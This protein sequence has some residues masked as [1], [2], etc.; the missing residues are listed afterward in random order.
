MGSR[1]RKLRAIGALAAL[2]AGMVGVLVKADEPPRPPVIVLEI[3]GA[4]GP[5]TADYLH[6][7]FEKAVAAHAALIVLRMDTPGGL[8]TS[9]REIIRDILASEVP[10]ATLVA[11]AGARAASA[12]TYI[13]YASHIAAMVP[14]TNLGAA[15]PVSLGGGSPEPAGGDKSAKREVGMHEKV[16]NDASAYIRG[17][18]LLRGRNADWA[19]KA[20]REAASLT[21]EDAAKEKV[22]DLLVPDLP[23]LLAAVDG[24]RVSL[25]SGERTLATKDAPVVEMRPDW[26]TQL[27]AVITDPSIAYLLMIFGAYA[28]IFEFM[29]PGVIVPGIVG[30]ISLLIAA[31]ALHV[32]PVNFA[33]LALLALGLGLMVAEIFTPGVAAL[34]I[35]G[36]ISF[37]IGSI[38]LF[39]TDATTPEFRVA[40]PV[41]GTVSALSAAAF[42]TFFSLALR[43]RRLPVVSGRERLIGSLG[44]V[45][46]WSGTMGRVRA[47]GETWRAVSS[48]PLKPGQTVRVVGLDGITLRVE[49]A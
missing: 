11:P 36:A 48:T 22:V 8:D 32:L 16:V 35:S 28:L 15:T 45:V 46:D 19:E 5:A 27:L 13:M 39:D 29:H 17:L 18:A 40:W 24:K 33:G 49:P 44:R 4:I 38:M 25:P 9:M 1:V 34:G 42:L 37:V 21:A 41:I 31:Y 3:N 10:V 14:G 43:A 2:A 20:V 30:A 26:R 12:G 7:G 6:R 47:E 23:H